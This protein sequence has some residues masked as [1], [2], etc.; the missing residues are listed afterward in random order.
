MKL[1]KKKKYLTSIFLLTVFGILLAA[2]FVNAEAWDPNTGTLPNATIKGIVVKA[3]NWLV[4]IVATIAVI[5]ILIS[6]VLWV[7]SGGNEERVKSARRFLVGGLAGLL[8]ALGAWA[9]VRVITETLF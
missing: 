9:I 3:I 4:G 1:I 7:T 2:A 6:G 8:V 5:I